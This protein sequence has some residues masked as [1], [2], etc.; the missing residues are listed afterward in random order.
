[1]ITAILVLGL[2]STP[3]MKGPTYGHDMRGFLN[4]KTHLSGKKVPRKWIEQVQGVQYD[5]EYSPPVGRPAEPE[6][7]ATTPVRF[8]PAYMR[9]IPVIV[10]PAPRY[11]DEETVMNENRQR[12]EQRA[13][14]RNQQLQQTQQYGAQGSNG[15]GAPGSAGSGVTLT[16][17][18][19]T[20]V[21]GPLPSAGSATGSNAIVTYGALP[22][23][24][25]ATQAGTEG[26]DGTGG[27]N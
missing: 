6:P 16:S 19:V 7:S 18:D 5:G 15:F 3:L 24:T 4:P 8:L 11:V 12:D 14:A 20:P 26:Q 23:A 9:D 17:G 22:A 25:G 10:K 13:Q 21:P 1:M 2:A 27:R